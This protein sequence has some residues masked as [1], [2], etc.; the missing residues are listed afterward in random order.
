MFSFLER[1]GAHALVEPLG[2]WILYL[3]Q[4][5]RA[6]LRRGRTLAVR[7][8][9]PWWVRLR[10]QAGAD[11]RAAG[12]WLLIEL[13]ERIYCG[14]YARVRHALGG[15][16]HPLVDQRL[17]ARL[18]DPYYSEMARGG[19]GHLEVAKNIYYT[20]HKAAH[21]VL[22]LKPFGCMPS[23]QSDGVQSAVVAR[24]PDMLYVPVETAADGELAAHNRVQMAL[25]E[26]R[27]RA[28][29]EL[30]KVLASTGRTLE[31]IQ[32]YVAD[33]PEL[34]RAGYRVPHHEGVAGVA[35]NFVLHVH[36]LMGRS[37]R[38]IRPFST[39]APRGAWA[40]QEITLPSWVSRRPPGEARRARI[41]G[42]CKR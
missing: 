16:A 28:E 37:S 5:A 35:A 11:A 19:E 2:G 9:D 15:S 27:A 26:A 18:A 17:L 24:F 34:R 12:R 14:Q 23:T 22:S 41:P 6:R 8:G 25:V 32:A 33:H 29:A 1:E 20:T 21:M 10:A 31:D 42:V 4:Y 30:A 13:S 38:S 3:L 40:R 36:R 7:H 39:T